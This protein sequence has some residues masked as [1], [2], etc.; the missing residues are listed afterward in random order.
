M[1]FDYE[2]ELSNFDFAS[3]VGCPS[4]NLVIGYVGVEDGF[5]NSFFFS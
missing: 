3:I 1:C 4:D 5:C 2:D